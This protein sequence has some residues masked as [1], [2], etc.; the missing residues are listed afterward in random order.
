MSSGNQ[1]QISDDSVDGPQA[2]PYTKFF[3]IALLLTLVLVVWP[4]VVQVVWMLNT[5]NE[6]VTY[7]RWWAMDSE[8]F[9]WIIIV[10]ALSNLVCL[11]IGIILFNTVKRHRSPFI[12]HNFQFLTHSRFRFACITNQIGRKTLAAGFAVALLIFPV[13][14]YW[15]LLN[16]SVHSNFL[17][18]RCKDLC[19][20]M[21]RRDRHTDFEFGANAKDGSFIVTR[22][23][24]SSFKVHDPYASSKYN[25]SFADACERY[26]DFDLKLNLDVWKH[27]KKF[28]PEPDKSW[29]NSEDTQ[30]VLEQCYEVMAM[31]KTRTS[32]ELLQRNYRV[33]AFNIAMR[34]HYSISSSESFFEVLIGAVIC[35]L[36]VSAYV[37]MK[38]HG[39]Q[40]RVRLLRLLACLNDHSHKSSGFCLGGVGGNDQYQFAKFDKGNRTY[41]DEF[42]DAVTLIE[43]GADWRWK[44]TKPPPN[45]RFKSE[46]PTRRI[47]RTTR[48]EDTEAP[49]NVKVQ[50]SFVSAVLTFVLDRSANKELESKADSQREVLTRMKNIVAAGDF[51]VAEKKE[52]EDSGDD[53]IRDYFRERLRPANYFSGFENNQCFVFLG[54]TGWLGHAF[55]GFAVRALQ[56]KNPLITNGF[57]YSLFGSVAFGFLVNFVLWMALAR[58]IDGLGRNLNSIKAFDAIFQFP[59]DEALDRLDSI[60]DVEKEETLIQ[61]LRVDFSKN[62]PDLLD[63]LPKLRMWGDIRNMFQISQNV[64]KVDMELH[65]VIVV[66]ALLCRVAIVISNFFVLAKGDNRKL[67]IINF[68]VL[69]DLIL[70]LIVLFKCV[71]VCKD[72][73]D[74]FSNHVVNLARLQRHVALE[75]KKMVSQTPREDTSAQKPG[76]S[77]TDRT[78]KAGS[79]GDASQAAAQ[80]EREAKEKDQQNRRRQAEEYV[81]A[82]LQHIE[83][84]DS[85]MRLFGF[86]I[87]RYS[88]AATVSVSLS[89]VV[90]CLVPLLTYLV[91]KAEV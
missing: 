28:I 54:I 19:W 81:Q 41:L 69:Y 44:V 17:F 30:Y 70:I 20:H 7:R 52:R 56:N 47:C 61:R 13:A 88:L 82:F 66:F 42:Y 23:D 68:V 16:V 87:N 9:P 1:A 89:F 49:G 11:G 29:S 31:S 14:V 63:E 12:I 62:D 46:E 77:D 78:L 48:E 53:S 84:S 72:V 86:V 67:Q 36:L 8:N 79:S 24:G 18:F 35:M 55:V 90:P 80:A 25:I 85:P 10:G 43:D 34:N 64:E 32:E 74:A 15:P 50:Q 2:P 40:V 38:R 59:G 60:G 65:L 58:C 91:H 26:V 45:F 39:S 33:L 51:Q 83:A 57:A 5:S 3:G 73:N 4:C 37:S 71:F 27:D 21:S 22:E 76:V 75:T 6:R